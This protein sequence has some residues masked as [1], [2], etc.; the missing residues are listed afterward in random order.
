MDSMTPRERFHA[1]MSFQPFDRLPVV[2]WAIWWDKTIERWHTEGLPGALTDRYAINRH[3]GQDVYL[4]D[5]VNVRRP[6]CPPGPCVE[7]MEDYQR[8]RPCL[9]PRPALDPDMWS[10]WAK[11]QAS[12]EVVLWFSV[13][14]FFW[15]PRTLLGIEQHLYAFYDKPEL[16]HCIN[17]DLCAWIL[18]VIDE[19]CA[20]CTPDFMTFGED[21]SYNHG[22]MLSKSLFD[23]FLEPYYSRVVPA[24]D[25]RGILK[26]VDSDGDVTI[27]SYWFEGA[28]LDGILPL[29]RQ[30]GVDIA[31]LRAE[32]P[33]MRFI[34]HYDKMVMPRGEAEMRAEFERLLPVAA[35]GGFI[36]SVDH[37]TP[38]GVSYDE[39][40]VFMRL[41]REYAYRAG[42]LSSIRA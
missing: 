14:G 1:V 4:Q 6:D 24:L 13:E 27:P 38:P 32:H 41:F 19:I 20:I 28:G 9:F 37:Q 5:W 22:P 12:G 21:L 31:R 26:I 16:M 34:G 40:L 29:E 11:Q 10:H 23:E 18:D 35:E 2:E 30:A 17:E 15:F 42:R 36:I 25:D 8:L 3:F 39:Y 33:T 7:T